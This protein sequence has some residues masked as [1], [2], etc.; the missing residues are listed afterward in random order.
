MVLEIEDIMINQTQYDKQ[1][2]QLLENDLK[3]QLGLLGG[4]QSKL[5]GANG[6]S[7]IQDENDS[8]QDSDFSGDEEDAKN[9]K[10]D[11]NNAV[12][13]NALNGNPAENDIIELMA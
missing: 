7:I 6:L 13:A 12:A 5:I 4:D 8:N 11:S 2:Q 3:Q 1:A 10:N 9:N